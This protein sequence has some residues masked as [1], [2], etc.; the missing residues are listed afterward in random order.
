MVFGRGN[1]NEP[2]AEM[3]KPRLPR[4]PQLSVPEHSEN[5]PAVRRQYHRQALEFG[6]QFAEMEDRAE[7]LRQERDAFERRAILAEETV[8]HLKE[9]MEQERMD[10]TQEMS[11]LK[12]QNERLRDLHAVLKTKIEAGAKIFLGCLEEAPLQLPV[13][14]SGRDE[15]AL[16]DDLERQITKS[17]EEA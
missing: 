7:H 11:T 5:L 12:G 4:G 3:P 13:P 8:D 2:K 16:L 14:T 9:R 17:V 10:H 6:Q 15:A 1:N